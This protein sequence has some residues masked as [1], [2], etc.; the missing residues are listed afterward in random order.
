MYH[1]FSICTL[2]SPFFTC[3]KVRKLIN[4]KES[5]VLSFK[6]L[7]E[8]ID[9][10]FNCFCQTT[11]LTLNKLK[12]S[13]VDEVKLLSNQT[14]PNLKELYISIEIDHDAFSDLIQLTD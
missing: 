3:K 14:F 13:K 9:L 8:L 1:G 6:N 11:F 2:L 12:Y 5:K 7:N 10:E 4:A